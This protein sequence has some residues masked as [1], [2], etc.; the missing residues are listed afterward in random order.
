MW[1]DCILLCILQ[2]VPGGPG[3]KGENGDVGDEGPAVSEHTMCEE[4]P[5]SQFPCID[6]I[7]NT[8]VSS[9]FPPNCLPLKETC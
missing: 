4:I 3:E 1:H 5:T 8:L 7:L 6:A 9:I 2:G